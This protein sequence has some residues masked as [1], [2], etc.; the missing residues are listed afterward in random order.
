MR[1]PRA[2]AAAAALG[3]GL[4]QG[5]TTQ[6]EADAYTRYELLGPETSQ[7]RIVYEVSATSAGATAYYNPI[8]PGS[9]ATGEAVF[10]RLTGE[11]LR[12]EVVSGAR[13]RADGHAEADP[14]TSYI[15]VRLARPVPREGEARLVIEKTYKDAKSYFREGDQLVFSRPLGVKRNAVVL[16]AG[17]ELVGCNVPAQVLAEP[18]GRILVSFMNPLPGPAPLVVRARRLP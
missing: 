11:A 17:Y 12:F 8:R 3:T 18:D 9:E 16:P 10:D 4:A 14:Q 13:A 5:A 1:F 2:L 6:T 7:F 15:K